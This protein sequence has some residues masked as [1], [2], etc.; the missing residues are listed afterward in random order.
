MEATEA[1]NRLNAVEGVTGIY[2][3]DDTVI[4]NAGSGRYSLQYPM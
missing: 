1:S 4:F 3:E 2:Q